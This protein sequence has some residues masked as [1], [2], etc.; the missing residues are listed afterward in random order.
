MR[1]SHIRGEGKPL[2]PLVID[3]DGT[4][5]QTD[6]LH[7][8]TFR[9]VRDHPAVLLRIPAWLAKGKAGLKH[10]LAELADL[11]VE[12]LPY[13]EE[14]LTWLREQ[15]A[16]GR[17]VVL[18]TASDRKYAQAIAAHLGVFDQVLASDGTTNLSGASK[19]DAL[20]KQFGAGE[21][22]YA[23]N[24]ESDLPV[25]AQAHRAI[26]VNAPPGLADKAGKL[27][28]VERIFPRAATGPATW[29]RVLRMHQWMKNL[30]LFVPLLGAHAFAEPERW[31]MAL[32]GLLAFSLCASSVYIVNDLL[33]LESDRLHIRKR[34]R[35]F[36]SGEVP[37]WMGAWLAPLLLAASAFLAYLTGPAFMGWLG[38]YFVL[39]TAY[40]FGLKRIILLDCLVLALLYT[41][42][43][44][45]G[46]AAA[47][48]A[49]SFWLLA[50]SVFLFLSLAFV[51][52]YAELHFQQEQGLQK[53]HGRGYYTSD[54]SLIQTMGVTAG[55]GAALVLALY[56]NSDDVL[57]LYATP[58]FIWGA[59]PVMLFWI[60]WMW[61]QAH[62]GRMHDD[63]VIFA[64]KDRA[65]LAAGAA[66]L[67]VLGMGTVGW[68]WP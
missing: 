59:V 36:A 14:L 34:N 3:L 45:A 16:S 41:L 12:C 19:A 25:W 55:Y 10:R 8:S 43:I 51:K 22:D 66:F 1:R 31:A 29:R 39:T 53:A 38:A 26:V 15:K 32:L 44:V 11:N 67:A 18:C 54:A 33:D 60:S 49:L 48:L 68:T 35:P 5:L 27:A 23:G 64:L 30:L 13:H 56:L 40:S 61:L 58:V 7:E 57:R 9:A 63:P 2:K 21:F 42:R 47:S 20:V 46:A 65:S 24:H 62:R 4:L 28:T 37:V 17:L 6:M 52:R 50:F